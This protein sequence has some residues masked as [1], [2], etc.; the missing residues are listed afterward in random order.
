MT[1]TPSGGE[2]VNGL[3]DG[4]RAELLSLREEVAR[5]RTAP[6]DVAEPRPRTH[7]GRAWGRTVAAVVLITVG[8]ILTPLAV[9]SVWAK[10]VVTD[11]D[12]YV[13]TVAP[14][15]KDPAVQ[16]AIS[17]EITNTVFQYVDITGLTQQAFD[18][19]ANASGGRV[20]AQ[21]L[22][23]LAAPVANGI[24]SF[25][26]GQ[27]RKLVGSQAFATAWET[28][29]RTAHQQL[30]DALSGKGDAVEVKN[31][32]VSLNLAP[33]IATVKKQLVDSGFQL[34]E[35]IPVVNKQFV[36][37]QSDDVT[38]IQNGFN[39]LNT[40]GLWLP[41]VALL[42]LAVGIYAARSHRLA[43]IGA[44]LGIALAML[45]MGVA[46]AI[47]RRV[48]LDSVP[49]GV[50]PQDAAVAIFDTV[51]RFF[52]EAIRA[53]GV[54]GLVFALGAFF[55]GPSV[56]ATKTR[57]VLAAGI[58]AIRRGVASIGLR[59]QSVYE[60]TSAHAT[61]LRAGVVLAAGLVLV[62]WGNYRTAQ[63]VLWLT[64]AVLAG[65]LIVQFLASPPGPVATAT[66]ADPAAVPP[67]PP[68]TPRDPSDDPTET[69][70]SPDSSLP[71]PP[72][73]TA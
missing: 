27:V 70:V 20:S 13:E 59:M 30:V 21:Q 33:F 51:V 56:T 37:F 5:P 40:L 7:R 47:A 32:T 71:S 63:L 17:T 62:F 15:A 46:L 3:T 38:K 8:V 73:V 1:E 49:S 18:A 72:P 65:L 57:S 55:T 61:W 54:F 53:A 60:W 43:F 45:L 26:D 19:L 67:P 64:V 6:A 10:S 11:T 14:L 68:P 42:L 23:A 9:V 44:G 2:S 24:R 29:N 48:Y 52:R 4:E 50:L 66:A 16:D 28:A 41:I 39:L 22:D 69:L 34:A 35:R 31:G 12:R 36:L 25:T 58:A